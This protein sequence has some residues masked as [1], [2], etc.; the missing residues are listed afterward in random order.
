MN[1][2]LFTD[3]LIGAQ[4]QGNGQF[5]AERPGRGQ[6]DNQRKLGRLLDR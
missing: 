6:I 4:Q 1:S 3:D 5:D 2:R